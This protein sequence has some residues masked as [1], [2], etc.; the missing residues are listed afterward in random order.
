MKYLCDI[1]VLPKE[2][3][4]TTLA[5]NSI[6][7]SPALKGVHSHIL[8]THPFLTPTSGFEYGSLVLC[9]ERI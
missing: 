5:T 2:N 3:T 7:V 9:L 6:L 4:R 8:P 1:L